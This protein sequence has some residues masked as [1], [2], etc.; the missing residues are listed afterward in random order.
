MDNRP[1][2]NCPRYQACKVYLLACNYFSSWVN[3]GYWQP[4]KR[5]LAPSRRRY[6]LLMADHHNEAGRPTRA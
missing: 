1:C 3:F 6:E 2:D 5:R 4:H